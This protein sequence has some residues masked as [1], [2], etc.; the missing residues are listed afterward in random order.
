[1]AT[2]IEIT[3]EHTPGLY[4]SATGDGLKA[5]K[6]VDV[7]GDCAGG[8]ERVLVLYTTAKRGRI[9]QIAYPYPGEEYMGAHIHF[10]IDEPPCDSFAHTADR[11]GLSAASLRR[12]LV[13]NAPADMDHQ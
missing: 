2:P 4:D 13:E 12:L 9:A 6:V 8:G 11:L 3:E 7:T 1:M 5:E 10:F